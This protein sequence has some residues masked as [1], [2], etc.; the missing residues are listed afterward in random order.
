MFAIARNSKNPQAAWEFL[1]F[2]VSETGIKQGLAAAQGIPSRRSIAESESFKNVVVRHHARLGAAVPRLP[3][4]GAPGA[5]PAP[6]STRCRTRSS[7]QLDN[8]WSFKE[9]P[10][11][12][13]PKVCEKVKPMLAAGGAPGG[14]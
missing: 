11:V 6:T 14:G 2:M 10:S 12:V 7:A 4:D 3:A 8:M 9:P 13:L 5:Q 1:K